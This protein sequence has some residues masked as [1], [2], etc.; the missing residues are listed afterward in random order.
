MASDKV[1]VIT[2]AQ[3]QGCGYKKEIKS[4]LP[5]GI[6]EKAESFT[7][8]VCGSRVVVVIKKKKID[9]KLP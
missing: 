1:V 9:K 4:T 3:C 7:C 5:K 8:P 2:T 6:T